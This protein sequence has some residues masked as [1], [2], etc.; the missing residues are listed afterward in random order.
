MDEYVNT[1]FTVPLVRRVSR[2]S[3]QVGGEE[4]TIEVVLYEVADALG[5]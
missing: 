3:I 4:D 2:R 1:I 5:L